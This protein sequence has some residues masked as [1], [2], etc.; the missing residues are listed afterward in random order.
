MENW[1]VG[2]LTVVATC[3]VGGMVWKLY[4]KL[5][6]KIEKLAASQNTLARE[7]A[8]LRGELRGTFGQQSDDQ[9]DKIFQEIVKEQIR[10]QLK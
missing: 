8:E 3:T 1:H 7:F 9:H 2:I 10:G 5:D 6:E 4:G